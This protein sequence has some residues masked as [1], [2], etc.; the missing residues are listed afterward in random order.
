MPTVQRSSDV[1]ESHSERVVMAGISGAILLAIGIVLFLFRGEGTFT[2]LSIMLLSG[3]LAAVLYAGYCAM[4][5]R[6]VASFDL[7]TSPSAAPS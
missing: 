2:I 6:K 7:R 5:V 4:Q 3:G 1:V